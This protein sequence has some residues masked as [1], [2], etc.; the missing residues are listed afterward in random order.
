MQTF[1]LVILSVFICVV[2]LMQWTLAW[3]YIFSSAVRRKMRE[4]L[5]GKSR[6]SRFAEVLALMFGFV[7]VNSFIVAILWRVLVGP[8]KPIH[9]W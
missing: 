1:L 9:E 7:V 6:F 2:F 3:G 4:D 5:R 8:I